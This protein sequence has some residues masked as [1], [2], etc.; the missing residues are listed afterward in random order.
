MEKQRRILT[1]QDY[2]CLGRCSLTVAQ[3]T[4]SACG[5]ECVGI[6]TAIL[7][8]HT[9]FNSWTFVDLTEELDKIVNKWDEYNHS[10]NCIYTGYL[11]TSQIPIVKGII[12]KLQDN[13]TL[14]F[15]D[16]AMADNGKLYAG[17]TLEHVSKMKELF[18]GA[19]YVKPNITEACLLVGE[20][21]KPN[22]KE[23]DYYIN[24]AKK[25]YELGC[26]NVIL[27][28]VR[29]KEDKIGIVIYNA[30]GYQYIEN[31]YLN[32]SYHGTGD[33]FSSCLCSLL[34]L[35]KDISE[36]LRI[37]HNYVVKAIK[38]TMEDGLDGL[39]YGPEFERAIPYLINEINK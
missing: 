19:D 18:S 33:L 28:G 25:V 32:I 29:V 30:N 20:E 38:A 10:F 31:E 26:K 24:L 7:S 39:L 13:N 27:T 23:L 37:S 1:I 11:S 17:F 36:A 15:I 5:I 12:N 35:N 34:T 14:V 2:S 3:P 21:Y 9:Q 8:N 16:P 4:I 6:P 22:N